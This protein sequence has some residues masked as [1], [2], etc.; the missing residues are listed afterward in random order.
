MSST[1]FFNQVNFA[2]EDD[3]K[4]FWNLLRELGPDRG[5]HVWVDKCKLLSTVDLDSI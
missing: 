3:F 2:T 1:D 5:L 4:R